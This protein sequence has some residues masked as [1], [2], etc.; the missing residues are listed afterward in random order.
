MKRGIKNK[1]KEPVVLMILDG[2]G[3]GPAYEGNA[4]QLA[5]TPNLDRFWSMG[6]TCLLETSGS[7]VGLPSGVPGNSEV[8]HLNIGAGRIITQMVTRINQSVKDKT[9]YKNRAILW[10]IRSSRAKKKKLHIIGLLSAAGIHSDIRHLYAVLE[11]CKREKVVPHLH[12][13]T[14]GRDTDPAEATFYLTKLYS[15]LLALK[16]PRLISSIGGRF[17]AMDRNNQW[18]R[19]RKAYRAMIGVSKA[20]AVDPMDVIQKTYDENKNDETLEPT[21]IV[22][23]TGKP[24]GA[25][26]PDDYVINFNFREDRARQITKSFVLPEQEWHYFKRPVVNRN[27]VTMTN[28]EAGLGVRTAFMAEQI[29]VTLSDIVR[30][31][32]LT[33]LHIAETEK[34]AHVTYFFNGGRESKHPGE[35]F[36]LIES[37]KVVEYAEVPAMAAFT[38]KDEVVYYIKRQEYDFVLVNLANP[39]MVGHSGQ[40]GP[41]IEAIE[42]TDKC[43]GEIVTTALKNRAKVI[44]TADHGNIE[45]EV[46]R[47]NGLPDRNHTINPVPFIIL[48]DPKVLS[49]SWSG[50]K[51]KRILQ[52]KEG[53]ALTTGILADVGVT[54]LDLLG[55]K[56][57]KNMS[58]ISLLG[59]AV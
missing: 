17:W 59:S 2:L 23:K 13:I 42:V 53:Q 25:I 33:Q 34:Y 46:N 47:L 14:D 44:I 1:S 54:A 26:K 58:G 57:D 19:T 48:D 31:A 9:F 22:D 35:S 15:K 12:L 49:R 11:I 28:Y 29:A 4:I 3:Y 7:A 32:N 16:M 37:P 36:F 56:P 51:K 52:L 39:D 41:S 27:F 18:E 21:T 38:I 40:L 10:A 5:K 30:Q 55:L 6:R 24:I 20:K 43:V 45:Y 50:T 8:G